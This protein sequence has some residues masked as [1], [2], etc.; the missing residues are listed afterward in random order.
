MRTLLP[1][2]L[3][4]CGWDAPVLLDV[5]ARAGWGGSFAWTTADGHAVELTDA[6]L[7]IVSLRLEAPPEALVALPSL[8]PVARAH[9]GHDA[10]GAVGGEWLGEAALTL[11]GITRLG[12]ARCYTGTYVTGRLQ[13]QGDLRL[14][15][16]VTL[17]GGGVVPFDFSGPIDREV[18]GVSFVAQIHEDPAPRAI[19]LTAWPEE[20]L[21]WAGWLTDPG[22]GLLDLGDGTLANSVPFGVVSSASWSL[23]LAE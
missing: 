4:A 21:R 23:E 2:T 3:V 9:P 12:L 14:A 6:S 18:S 17:A 11:G 15:G 7:P 19:V 16:T 20:L 1:L 5:P 8:L 13:L 10:S 22:D